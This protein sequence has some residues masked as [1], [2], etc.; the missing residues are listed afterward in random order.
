MMKK[1]IG[2]LLAVAMSVLAV[3]LNAGAFKQGGDMQSGH[4]FYRIENGEAVITGTDGNLSGDVEIPAYIDGYKVVKI[5]YKSIFDDKLV[6]VIV[7]G[8][9]KTIETSNFETTGLNDSCKSI[10][11]SEGVEEIISCCSF[12]NSATITIPK[13][14]KNIS[15][16]FYGSKDLIVDPENPY[17]TT[18]NGMMYN[19]NKTELLWVSCDKSGEFTVDGVDVVGGSA[20][21]GCNNITTLAF[22]E[23][24][25]HIKSN[26]VGCNEMLTTIYFPKSL[27]RLEDQSWESYGQITDIYYA[28]TKEQWDRIVDPKDKIPEYINLHFESRSDDTKTEETVKDDKTSF[29]SEVSDWAKPDIEDAYNKNLIPE[30]LIGDDLKERI[31]RAEFAAVAITLLEEMTGREYQVRGGTPFTDVAE[32]EDYEYISKAY[33]ASI[34]AGTSETTFSPDDGLNREQLATMLCRVIK[35]CSDENYTIDKDAEYYLDTSGV[36]KFDD[37]ADISDYARNSVYYMAKFGIVNGI[38]DTHFAPKNTTSKQ[39]AE[40]YATA[41]KEQA[42]IMALRIFKL[43]D[44]WK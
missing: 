41:T 21:W 29:G 34:T 42:V 24:I 25:S 10:T 26:N 19:K 43:S 20:L 40:G 17:Y 22:A 28:G 32:H 2:L 16:A 38:D 12:L 27:N 13:S 31:S 11:F 39:E 3:P 1:I 14:V 15:N 18:E 8:T 30:T 6:N 33:K 37:D 44:L 7:P 4:Y 35:S 9:I 23:G 5:E 36:K